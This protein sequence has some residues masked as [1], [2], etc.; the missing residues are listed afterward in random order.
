VLEA[1]GVLAGDAGADLRWIV[2]LRG[3]EQLLVDLGL[4]DAARGEVFTTARD[5]LDREH[6]TGTDFHKQLGE[7][8]RS[9]KAD[10]DRVLTLPD[11]AALAAGEDDP[12]G[13]AVAALVRR[14]ERSQAFVA[15]LRA[16]D[17]AGALT[18]RIRGLAWSTVH[19]HLN[20]LLHASQ[21]AQELVLYD[22]LRRWHAA[23]RARPHTP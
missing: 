4:D 9:R 12:L 7:R 19:M 23:R 17:E 3:A 14:S 13:Q 1:L 6:R 15:E 16:R 5:S 22:F 20:R 11:A 8:F 2:G 21:R 18:P 10:I